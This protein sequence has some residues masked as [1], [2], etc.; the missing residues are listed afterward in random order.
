MPPK[1]LFCFHFDEFHSF[2]FLTLKSQKPTRRTFAASTF[3]FSFTPLSTMAGA[4]SIASTASTEESTAESS[5]PSQAQASQAHNQLRVPPHD[6][7]RVPPHEGQWYH[8]PESSDWDE[9]ED[10]DDKEDTSDQEDQDGHQEGD[11]DGHQDD[12]DGHQEG[13]D[14]HQEG[15]EEDQEGDEE[16]EDAHQEEAHHDARQE[17]AHQEDE[18]AHQEEDDQEEDSHQEEDDDA[19]Q[20]DDDDAHQEDDDE[21]REE[22]EE[23][24]EDQVREEDNSGPVREEDNS[25]PDP[26][27][28]QDASA[29]SSPDDPTPGISPFA[30]AAYT[31][32]DETASSYCSTDDISEQYY[33]GNR[34]RKC[35]GGKRQQRKRK[36]SKDRS[37][38]GPKKKKSNGPLPSDLEDDE[39]EVTTPS[40]PNK[41][42]DGPPGIKNTVIFLHNGE[43][44]LQNTEI[45][46][47]LAVE[48][49]SRLDP[50]K[51]PLEKCKLTAHLLE[52]VMEMDWQEVAMPASMQHR[53]QEWKSELQENEV[54]FR[55]IA[56]L[57]KMPNVEDWYTK[58]FKPWYEK[59][60]NGKGES[61]NSETFRKAYLFYRRL[62]FLSLCAAP[63]DTAPETIKAMVAENYS[64]C[65]SWPAIKKAS[66]DHFCKQFK[67]NHPGLYDQ[68]DNEEKLP[69]DR[70]V[71]EEVEETGQLDPDDDAQ[72]QAPDAQ[73]QA[74]DVPADAPDTQAPDAAADTQAP[75]DAPDTQAHAD[76]AP[77]EDVNKEESNKE[78]GATQ[79]PT[80]TQASTQIPT[81]TQASEADQPEEA[82]EADQPAEADQ[83]E[84]DPSKADQPEENIL[85]EA[86]NL[87][88]AQALVT[89]MLG[90]NSTTQ[91]AEAPA[92]TQNAPPE[93]VNKEKEGKALN[94]GNREERTASTDGDEP[95]PKDSSKEGKAAPKDGGNDFESKT[96]RSNKIFLQAPKQSLQQ[97]LLTGPNQSR[98]VSGNSTTPSSTPMGN[99]TTPSS[100]TPSSTA[101]SSDDADTKS[102]DVDTLSEGRSL[103]RPW[104]DG[105]MTM[106]GATP[107]LNT[108]FNRKDE[109]HPSHACKD[110]NHHSHPSQA[111]RELLFKTPA[112]ESNKKKRPAMESNENGDM[113]TKKPKMDQSTGKKAGYKDK[114]ESVETRTLPP[115]QTP[116]LSPG[117]NNLVSPSPNAFSPMG[118][119]PSLSLSLSTYSL[120]IL[121]GAKEVMSSSNHPCVALLDS[122][123][124]ASNSNCMVT[125]SS[126]ELVNFLNSLESI[127]EPPVSYLKR[128]MFD[129]QT[130]EILSTTYSKL[131]S[132]ESRKVEKEVNS[133]SNNRKKAP[134]PQ[135]SS[136]EESQ[137]LTTGRDLLP[138]WLVNKKCI[139]WNGRTT[140]VPSQVPILLR[141]VKGKA[142][143][144][145]GPVTQID[146][147]K[148][149]KFTEVT[150]EFQDEVTWKVMLQ[151][152]FLNIMEVKHNVCPPRRHW[153]VALNKILSRNFNHLVSG[154]MMVFAMGVCLIFSPRTPDVKVIAALK[155]IKDRDWLKGTSRDHGP[156]Y[157]L[158]AAPREELR[159]II[160]KTGFLETKFKLLIEC[161]EFL[162]MN[163]KGWFP[164]HP[165]YLNRCPGLGK[166]SVSIMLQEGTALILYPPCDMHVKHTAI[167]CQFI[168]YADSFMRKDAE[169]KSM[170]DIDPDKVTDD[171]TQR[172]LFRTIRKE[173]L[174][175]F[176]K[177]QGS[178]AQLLT[179][180]WK[181]EKQTGSRHC[182]QVDFALDVAKQHFSP[183]DSQTLVA[184]I[185]NTVQYYHYSQYL[186]TERRKE[187]TW[188]KKPQK[189]GKQPVVETVQEDSEDDCGF[190]DTAASKKDDASKLESTNNA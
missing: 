133:P 16:D 22:D 95:A 135:P 89:L 2:H 67:A 68:M 180:P 189:I 139:K 146:D 13:Q 92:G 1:P 40:L 115:T 63:P 162:A 174:R 106:V 65:K 158:L 183:H 168:E 153:D 124:K 144:Q 150:Q 49:A 15:D 91:S 29:A 51:S 83:P 28:E 165:K 7:L 177:I 27:E 188:A 151:T 170:F 107:V 64:K 39:P 21:V 82:S 172:R 103:F 105:F 128:E 81:D 116:P 117:Q 74:P 11:E 26:S 141:S 178:F 54:I 42:V 190:D 71:P 130:R 88:Q 62:Y 75:A 96:N 109:N 173:D 156:A 186:R 23:E 72:A 176:N 56:D 147:G 181:G 122:M 127:V 125:V 145:S 44:G 50:Q 118:L 100:T 41:V 142:K 175:N 114:D 4:N 131:T 53:V 79:I 119:C 86:D 164:L 185:E 24:E 179:Q 166:K 61:L 69:E 93:D 3:C 161:L 18:D 149:G 101:H 87:S 110:D 6:Q 8:E 58:Q 60:K 163:H 108:L 98:G 154:E 32:D 90:P 102:D 34:K 94:D 12:Q 148:D 77:T 17:E 121:K 187:E 70:V 30:S 129:G 143:D 66:E 73:A 84:E 184:M 57:P 36:P 167:S 97:D 136:E 14:G 38:S 10:E 59:Q 111:R 104:S 134:T 52:Q 46:R 85:S 138:S 20:E 152:H 80:D 99:S 113:T 33:A 112:P 140:P 35:R 19:H 160:A 78:K 9:D 5:V 182:G 25:G 47:Q 126:V 123:H 48:V 120:E 137:D 155:E 31:D 43:K 169:G 157:G 45:N 171:A 76:G 55:K 37:D 159:E 132:D